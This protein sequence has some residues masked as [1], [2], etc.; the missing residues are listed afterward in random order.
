MAGMPWIR[1]QTTIFDNPKLL[2]LRADKQWR[3]IVTHFEA[4]TYCGRTGLAGYVPKVAIG[5]SFQALVS[6]IN[7]LVAEGLWSPAPGG[8]QINSWEEYQF[9]DEAAIKRSEKAQLAA[10]KRWDEERKRR[11]DTA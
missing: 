6:D 1:L 8:W 4:M 7:R 3:A 9:S 10:R 5:N 11:G 2:N